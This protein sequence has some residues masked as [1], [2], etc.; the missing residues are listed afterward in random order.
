MQ[1]RVEA[2]RQFEWRMWGFTVWEV[3]TGPVWVASSVV[4]DL[5]C[6]ELWC[7]VGAIFRAAAVSGL[8]SHGFDKARETADD[9]LTQ[10]GFFRALQLTLRLSLGGL[11]WLAP[12]CASW[13]SLNL[14]NTKRQKKHLGQPA[15]PLSGAWK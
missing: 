3:L 8:R 15:M 2:T 10:E 9:I 13:V 5:D 11:L 7:G 6:A 14:V 12:V 4:R 1:Q